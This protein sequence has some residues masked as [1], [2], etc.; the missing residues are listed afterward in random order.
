MTRHI[1]AF[2]ALLSGLAAFGSPAQA[3][4]A[5]ALA[6]GSSIA[7][8]AGNEAARNESVAAQPAPATIS[9]SRAMESPSVAPVT[10]HALRLPVL[11]GIERAF[12]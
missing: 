1:L 12:E 4:L 8:A 3:S 11:M 5:E 6:C 10:P 9:A 7:A 2:L